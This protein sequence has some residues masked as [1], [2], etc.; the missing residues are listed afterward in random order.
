MPR[1]FKVTLYPVV[2]IVALILT[3]YLTC[4]VPLAKIL[5]SLVFVLSAV[6]AYFIFAFF[7]KRKEAKQG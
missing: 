4:L 5:W 1:P 6:P 3:V 2:P 7:R